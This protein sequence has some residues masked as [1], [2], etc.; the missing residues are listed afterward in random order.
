MAGWQQYLHSQAENF[1]HAAP[2][3]PSRQKR[4][5]LGVASPYEDPKARHNNG[6]QR[7][8]DRKLEPGGT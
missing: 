4:K 3:H 8:S 6:T 1:E 5:K 2:H 7:Q